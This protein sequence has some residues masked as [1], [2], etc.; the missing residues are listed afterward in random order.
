M[1]S[2][3]AETLARLDESRS[4]PGIMGLG[5]KSN[6]QMCAC[7]GYTPAYTPQASSVNPT[8]I[9]CL[10]F[11]KKC[12]LCRMVFYCN[13]ECQTKD[14]KSHKANCKLFSERKAEASASL[15][16][17]QGALW[18]RFDKYA[19]KWH[20]K[21]IKPLCELAYTVVTEELAPTC[22]LLINCSY[23]TA[24]L[25]HQQMRIETYGA[26]P[27][28][29]ACRAYP[30]SDLKYP[31]P[32]RQDERVIRY[33]VLIITTNLDIPQQPHKIV[34]SL[35]RGKNALYPPPGVHNSREA[36]L[37]DFDEGCFMLL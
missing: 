2:A 26:L 25:Q 18:E 16:S 30:N 19:F 14:W 13:R 23:S 7:C 11:L 3:D 12:S 10:I 4:M 33:R 5:P 29:V 28:E 27:L 24:R 37:A 36:I 1:S 21:H 15:G 20:D 17:A 6:Q 34:S 8:S 22:I 35:S 31:N 9:E 32:H